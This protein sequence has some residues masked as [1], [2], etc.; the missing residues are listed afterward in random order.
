MLKGE[1]GNAVS[2]SHTHTYS[3]RYNEGYEGG[4]IVVSYYILRGYNRLRRNLC[5]VN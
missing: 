3:Y 1:P 5:L 2:R 4:R